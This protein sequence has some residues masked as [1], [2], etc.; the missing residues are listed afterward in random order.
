MKNLND[1][2]GLLFSLAAQM[3]D[4]AVNAKNDGNLEHSE[5]CTY[6]ADNL[7]EALGIGAFAPKPPSIPDLK[8]APGAGW[9]WSVNVPDAMRFVAQ[10]PRRHFQRKIRGL[11]QLLLPEP[12]SGK[13]AKWTLYSGAWPDIPD[14]SWKMA[15]L[16]ADRADK[17]TGRS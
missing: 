3:R 4:R 1:S 7:D 16:E 10:S 6:V 5:T 8:P 17:E 13:N 15:L 9:V 12:H 14:L 11:W 2:Y